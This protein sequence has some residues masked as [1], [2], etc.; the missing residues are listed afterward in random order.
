MSGRRFAVEDLGIR[1]EPTEKPV[2]PEG[3]VRNTSVMITINL[4]QPT[5]NTA[6]QNR[7][8]RALSAF[9]KDTLSQ[10][11]GLSFIQDVGMTFRVRGENVRIPAVDYN[12]PSVVL[13]V[14]PQFVIEI[15]NRG[16]VHA[17]IILRIRHRT[18]I[19]F[20]RRHIKT[21]VQGALGLPK[22]PNVKIRL[23]GNVNEEGALRDYFLK[24]KLIDPTGRSIVP[25]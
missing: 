7:Q 19:H 12:D 17:H 10:P 21:M 1:R 14:V 22:P 20:N 2:A 8:A 13:S 11:D 24:S 15:G 3:V 25:T 18:R 5:L 4:N 6:E 9:V 16:F 23:L